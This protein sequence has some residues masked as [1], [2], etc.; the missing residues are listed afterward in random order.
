M[1]WNDPDAFLQLLRFLLLSRNPTHSATSCSCCSTATQRHSIR[2]TTRRSVSLTTPSALYGCILLSAFLTLAPA[3]SAL[4]FWHRAHH[5]EILQLQ[6]IVRTCRYLM[7]IQNT[8][9]AHEGRAGC[10]IASHKI[11]AIWR[12]PHTHSGQSS[13]AGHPVA[14]S[15]MPERGRTGV[16]VANVGC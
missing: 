5:T 8:R 10:G 2:H 6:L 14:P 12:H 7:A 16:R 3:R 15:N 13:H 9:I 4:L 1:P 11:V